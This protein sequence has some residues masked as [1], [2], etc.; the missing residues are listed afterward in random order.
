M[1]LNTTGPHQ[2]GWHLSDDI[3]N[4]LGPRQNGRHFA[5]DIFKCIFV[6]ENVWIPMKISLKFVPKGSINNNPALFQI[7]AWRRPGNKLLSEP[8]MVSSLTH[9]CVTRLQWVKYNFM[10][11]NAMKIWWKLEISWIMLMAHAMLCFRDH[12]GYG[13]SHWET[14]LRCNVVS[15]WL[16]PNSERSLCLDHCDVLLLDS[17]TGTGQSYDCFSANEATLKD[18]CKR[19]TWIFKNWWYIHDKPNQNKTMCIYMGH[20]VAVCSAVTNSKEVNW[21]SKFPAPGHSS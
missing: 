10:D 18:V 12:S 2:N 11:E 1:V 15:H 9:I 4:T 16:S 6:N 20:T 5:D 14:T 21:L 17:V 8:M 7:M 13:P 19:I 3:F